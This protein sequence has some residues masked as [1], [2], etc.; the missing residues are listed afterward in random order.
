[1]SRAHAGVADV[2]EQELPHAPGADQLIGH[3]LRTVLADSEVSLALPNH[4]VHQHVWIQVTET[5]QVHRGSVANE[6]SDG[7]LRGC[8][9]R[10]HK[11]SHPIFALDPLPGTQ[12][13]RLHPAFHR[14][15]PASCR[16]QEN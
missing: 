16:T 12:T 8:Q 5:A 14:L 11:D 10:T 6:F 2:S 3:E 4:F 1:M 9:F 7:S 15:F 13:C